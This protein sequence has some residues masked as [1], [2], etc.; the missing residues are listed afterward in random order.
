MKKTLY[1]LICAVFCTAIQTLL[2]ANLSAASFKNV[3]E[4]AACASLTFPFNFEKNDWNNTEKTI[5]SSGVGAELQ[6]RIKPYGL[7][8]GLY[9]QFGF[10]QPR[11]ITERR[12]S[13]TFN[14]KASDY[15]KIWAAD[16]QAGTYFLAYEDSNWYVPFGFG[17]HY[18]LDYNKVTGIETS[19]NMFGL[20]AFIHG[21]YEF[22]NYIRTFVGLNVNYDFAGGSKRECSTGGSTTVYYSESGFMRNIGLTPK[23]GLVIFTK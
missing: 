1:L 20:S 3:N 12:N 7:P 10:S 8:F 11:K 21:E 22:S 6:G 5:N 13:K 2:S 15:S 19:S 9:A 14:E 17:L 4:I 16:F 18:K 23:I